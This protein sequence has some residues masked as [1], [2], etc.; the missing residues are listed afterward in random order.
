MASSLTAAS[1][2]I[3]GLRNNIKRNTVFNWLKSLNYDI[4]FLQETHCHLRKEIRKWSSEWGLQSLWSPGSSHSKGVAVLFNPSNKYN[5]VNEVIDV[6]GRF[7]TFEL[8]IGEDKYN[9]INIYAPNNGLERIKFFN[10]LNSWV[11]L[12]SQ[13][14][15]G[16][17][18]NCTLD[19]G[20][21]RLNCSE[22]ID[23]GQ[24]DL[25]YIMQSKSLEDVWRRR[26]PEKQIFSWTR[27]NKFSRLDFWLVSES[28]D[29]QIEKTDYL[30]CIFSDH[31]MATMKL[32]LS[33]VKHGPGVWKM[34]LS[35]IKSDLF[36]KCFK[37]MWRD[38]QNK[39]NTF[40]DCKIWWDLG[41]RK[42]KDLAIWC[43]CKIKQDR[44]HSKSV[45]ENQLK[46]EKSKL[47]QDKTTIRR[48]EDSL[49][50][51]YNNE[52][53][54]I[55]IRSR[56]QWYEEGEKPTSFFHNM[57][58][59]NAKNKSWEKILDKNNKM[60]FGTK[61]IL[62][63]QI[64]FYKQ[65]YSSEGVNKEQGD[66]FGQ[67]I[68]K[69]LSPE[70]R[71]I[72]DTEIHLDEV[73]AAL[74]KMN[75]NKSPGPDGI[76]VEFYKLYWDFIKNDL[77][78]V[79]HASYVTQE[80]P[81][82]Q[83]LAL[84]VLLYKKGVREMLTNWRP[85]SLSNCDMKILSKVFA[86]RLK[87]VLPEIIEVD[88]SGCIKGRKIG[89][90][91]RLIEDVLENM[92]DE[93]LILLIDQEKAFDRVEWD[94]MFYV[95]RKFNFGEYFINWIKILY[96]NMKSAI[97]T[98]GFLSPYFPITRGI[99]Q[100]DSLSALL[101][102]MQSEPL[103][104]CIRCSSSV[105]GIPINDTNGQ[106]NEIKGCQYVDDATHMLYSVEDIR[107]C[108]GIIDKFG[109]AS[110]SRVNKS[111]TIALVSEHFQEN[112]SL[113]NDIKVTNDIEKVLGVPMGKGQSKQSFWIN[114]MEKM[115]K[116]IKSW[117]SRDL[118]MFGKVYLVRSLILPLI[119]F[120][121]AHVHIDDKVI[122]SVQKMIWQFVWKWKTCFVSRS[123]C[124]LPRHLGG[125][126]VPNF[127]CIVKTSRIKMVIDI[128]KN[129]S[130][131]NILAQKYLRS[132]DNLYDVNWFAL[133]VDDSTEEINKSN[134]PDY[135]KQ[136]LL[137][138][139]ELNRKGR[140]NCLNDVIWCNSKIKFN[141][142][143]LSFRHWSKSGIQY[144]SN[145][146]DYS[147]GELDKAYVYAKLKNK[148]GF[149]FE[150][151]KLERSITQPMIDASKFQCAPS[152]KDMFYK[153]P[154]VN[155]LKNILEL[156]SKDVYT[157]LL[158]NDNY[159]NKSEEYWKK[160][161]N[162]DIDFDIWYEKLFTCSLIPRKVL[163]FN[164]RVF[165]G[166]I[167]TEK[168]L[169]I[170]KL[171]KG[172]CI[173]CNNGI[174]D[175][176]H[177]FVECSAFKSVWNYVVYVLK[178]FCVTSLLEFNMIVGFLENDKRY[179]IVNMIISIARWVIWKRRCALK[180]EKNFVP[181]MPV[182]DEFRCTLK[183][184]VVILLTSKKISNLVMKS[185]LNALMNM[186]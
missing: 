81:Y 8:L 32:N 154:G 177:L 3:S 50:I 157:I 123:L 33:S 59:T 152:I 103:S 175:V 170:M 156:S 144:V 78:N 141:N 115:E 140:N 55:K 161:W 119:Q 24:I 75:N 31:D 128:L 143:V 117:S 155:G 98:N 69:S 148:A 138:F 21:D 134:I 127:S 116:R 169:Q 95:L 42:I 17:D 150:Y 160:K 158:L 4:I 89:H 142:K 53:E 166:Q 11:K 85:I 97:L 137:A 83:Y 181:Q 23:I 167:V 111:K 74:K 27:G 25:K 145:L 105:R 66:F 101:Y 184:H 76:I 108:F 186:L 39:L 57:E 121:S 92:D 38:W 131:W 54:G 183:N 51:I 171:S 61:E 37:S 68:T 71:D 1:C 132:F 44:V 26:F 129:P 100:G 48:L 139:Q 20:K 79:Y 146:S 113:G 125:L 6:N 136:C 179:D 133:I 110:G 135:Y 73:L 63:T 35:V 96:K 15:V 58:K 9:F 164:W 47:N 87:I 165:H 114:K 163:D 107:F 118:S 182:R 159:E 12:D 149:I 106:T 13:T 72:V 52:A 173:C 30:P 56:V 176:T 153:I 86:E 19:T 16:G 168:R 91:I 99:R 102:V 40:S 5:I 46:C 29:S 77:M 130:K 80:L 172:L 49:Q 94:W 41:K 162:F 2:N 126:N 88:Q 28:L 185:D 22:K 122:E 109:E 84:I 82:S 151:S 178:Q 104:E 36:S 34:N 112:G 14:L 70:N 45:L 93:N 7:I 120:A 147:K 65:L 10:E 174:E 64:D 18:Y 43:A 124:Y 67:Y 60:L 180:F 90:N 62:N